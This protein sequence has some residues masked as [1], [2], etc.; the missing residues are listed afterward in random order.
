MTV[1]NLDD[2][3]NLSSSLILVAGAGA[4]GLSA[5]KVLRQLGAK[6]TICDSNKQALGKCA[7][8]GLSTIEVESLLQDS[9]L[10]N[11]FSLV[12]TSPG[13]P[14]SSPLFKAINLQDIP[15]WGDVELAWRI[16]QLQLFGPVRR[17]LVVTG[18]NGKT[19][20][21]SML[22][23]ILLTAGVKSAS[24][25]NIGRPILDVLV[26][27]ERTDVLA[28][29]LSSFQLYWAPSVIPEAGVI[30]NIAEDHL[31]W[32]GGMPE[33]IAAKSR[34]LQGRVGVLGLDDPIAASLVQGSPAEHTVGFRLGAPQQ[35]E[36]GIVQ[37]A[38]VDR[39]FSKQS[40][41]L[42]AVSDITPASSSL[43]M[44]ALAAAA[45]A[46]AIGVEPWAIH[47]GL[48]NHQLGPHR[49]QFVAEID[50]VRYIND[51]KATNPHAAKASVLAYPRV[52]WIAGGQL[53]GAEVA[54]L[55][56]EISAHLVAVVLIGC[57]RSH[58]RKAL[59]RHAPDVPV[60]EV[61]TS[62]DA[63]V[64]E[65][66]VDRASP[67]IRQRGDEVLLDSDSSVESIM[68]AAVTYARRFAE[69]G[70][71]VLLAPAAASLDMFNSYG[72]RGEAFALAVRAEVEKLGVSNP[73]TVNEVE[74]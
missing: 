31:D 54:G 20:T 11:R 15:V 60:L 10:L 57:D 50:G 34:V 71:T 14:P 70:D 30:L 13:W 73:V 35:G 42:A 58:I 33:Y 26:D 19:T 29:E 52:V 7:D 23:S 12:I 9:S 59:L 4:S 36:L 16:D 48:A 43:F 72:H 53:K 32:H 2:A 68:E 8:L 24:C 47:G 74:S 28:V 55:I 25:G 41:V 63:E 18:T 66:I 17:W 27:S 67:L 22:E 3:K 49:S 40:L 51:S 64:S 21:T 46:R 44:D 69:P 39:A 5:A 1:F 65:E 6:V 37:G 45:L 62:D 38:I 61:S 56:A